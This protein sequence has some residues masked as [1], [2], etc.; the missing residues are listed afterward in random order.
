MF[1]LW[2]YSKQLM[3]R[4]GEAKTVE[5][6]EQLIGSACDVIRGHQEDILNACKKS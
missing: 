2:G 5:E 3:Y 1:V 4:D 6:I